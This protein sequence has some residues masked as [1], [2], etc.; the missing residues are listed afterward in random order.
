[1]ERPYPIVDGDGH[2]TETEQ[3]VREY[4]PEPYRSR[5]ASIRAG[6]N[7]WNIN[8]NG[9]LGREARDAKTWLAALDE[10]GME[11][12]VLFPTSLGFTSSLIWEPDLHVAVC[13]AYNDFA[14]EEFLKVSPLLRPV[15]TLPMQDVD[16][17][18]KELRRTHEMGFVGA[19]LPSIGKHGLLGH[20]KFFPLY[21]EAEKLDIM[22]AVHSATQGI[23]HL[24]ADDFERF[25]DVN[26]YC[27]P[28]GL[29][30]QFVSMVFAG[31]PDMFPKLRVGWMEAGCGWVP[32]WLE[33]MDEK[34]EIRGEMETPELKRKPS[35]VVKERPWYFH[36]EADEHMLSYFISVMGADKAFFASDFPHWDGDYPHNVDEMLERDDL[37]ETA[38]R[39][40]MG[41]NAKELYRLS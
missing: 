7:Y 14:N 4:L 24:G 3:Q 31:I 8:L 34:W 39:K 23:H 12:A 1:M 22:L 26:T 10:G 17:A 28:V 41:E 18:V 15:A 36:T 21:A 20:R 38:K 6:N 30:R 5:G 13:K 2:I 9:T 32:Y 29:F 35:T 37:D 40:V 27:F 19:M 33:R 16:E 25:I 11:Q